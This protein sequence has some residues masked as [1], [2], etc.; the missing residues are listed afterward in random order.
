MVKSVNEVTQ[1]GSREAGV[2]TWVGPTPKTELCNC[3]LLAS[4]W[5]LRLRARGESSLGAPSQL[6]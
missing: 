1:L 4:F 3:L 2:G 6:S 5:R